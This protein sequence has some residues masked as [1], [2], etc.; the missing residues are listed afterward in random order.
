MSELSQPS[1]LQPATY[2]PQIR[3][4][5]TQSPA[6]PL[7]PAVRG[8]QRNLQLETHH[9]DLADDAEM[10]IDALKPGRKDM[11]QRL[12]KQ[13]TKSSSAAA[14]QVQNEVQDEVQNEVRLVLMTGRVVKPIE[15]RMSMEMGMQ[16]GMMVPLMIYR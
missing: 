2:S 5:S 1:V 4:A 3:S 10:C 7:N 8:V 13:F 6:P 14:T 9:Q 12:G 15:D 16:K 11:L